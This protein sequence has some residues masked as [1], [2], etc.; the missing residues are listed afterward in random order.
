MAEKDIEMS[1][2][3]NLSFEAKFAANLSVVNDTILDNVVSKFSVVNDHHVRG[4]WRYGLSVAVIAVPITVFAVVLWYQL[5]KA[6]VA[7]SQYYPVLDTPTLN[8]NVSA[9]TTESTIRDFL[10]QDSIHYCGSAVSL[11]SVLVNNPPHVI[12]EWSPCKIQNHD[13]N[14]VGACSEYKDLGKVL[15]GFDNGYC[16]TDENLFYANNVAVFYTQ[17]I[18]ISTALVTAIQ[19]ALYSIAATIV[20]YLVMRVGAKH[21]VT[22]LVSPSK[23]LEMLNN[24]KKDWKALEDLN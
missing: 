16:F 18:P 12:T 9:Y 3:G 10:S 5:M 17:C 24:G 19:T 13:F 14:S 11:L 7:N 6:C 15:K 4:K 20:L 22:G 8:G 21:G 1:R 2:Q 23:W